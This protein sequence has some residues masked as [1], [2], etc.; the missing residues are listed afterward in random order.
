MS[1]ALQSHFADYASFHRT[2]GNQA[3][4]YVGIPL[5][6]L[7]IYALLG[8]VHLFMLQGFAVTGAELLLVLVSLFYFRLDP[9]LALSMLLVSAVLIGAGRLVP[10]LGA[11]ALFVVGWVFQ[12]AGHYVYEHRSPAFY[13]NLSHL[14]VGPLWILAKALGRA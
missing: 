14:L 5:I 1:P 10:V 4:H 9:V 11:A 12:F 6:V 8:H 13:K 3:C 2:G 7:S